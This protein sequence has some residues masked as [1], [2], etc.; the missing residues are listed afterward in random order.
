MKKILFG[1][2]ILFVLVIIGAAVAPFVINLD[3]HKG[4]ILNKI[5]PYI[6]RE[7]DFD[8]V[9]LTV[10][11]GFGAELQGFRISG[12]PSFYKEDFLKLESLKIKIRL[13]PLLK[14]EYE[15]KKIILSRPLIRLARNADGQFCFNDL[16]AGVDSDQEISGEK[17]APEEA[18]QGPGILGVLLVNNLQIEKAKIIYQDDKQWPGAGALVI[19]DIDL[20]VK[21]FSLKQPVSV[22]LAA[23]LL[24]KGDKQ[25]FNLAGQIGPLGEEIAFDK[26]PM[27]VQVLFAALPIES[28]KAR[29]PADLPLLPLSGILNGKLTARGSLAAQLTSESQIDVQDLIIQMLD[30]AQA[31]RNSTPVQISF[32]H[33]IQLEY[34]NEKM[35]VESAALSLNGNRILVKGNVQNFLKLPKWDARIWTETFQPMSLAALMP[36]FLEKMPA[37]LELKG[38]AEITINSAGTKDSFNFDI[39]TNMAQM[40]VKYEE[41]FKKPAGTPFSLLSKGDKAAERITLKELKLNLHDLVMTTAGEIIQSAKPRFSLRTQTNSI[42][43]E[44]WEDLV[45]LLAPYNP[46]GSLFLRSSLFGK[47]NDASMNVQIS[48]DQVQFVLPA[49]EDEKQKKKA[50][51]PGNLQSLNLQR[52]VKKN[53]EGVLGSGRIEIKKGEIFINCLPPILYYYMV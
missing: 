17:D 44:G 6:P 33:N 2:A 10:L 3:K 24:E 30:E 20:K 48:S 36:M 37:E 7:V 28:L 19:D 38:P 21:D 45:P 12:N 53:N 46:R 52:Q 42:S 27:D 40:E 50:A 31:A 23:R 39:N 9:E 29:L 4:T 22:E 1:I 49:A 14:K 34:S 16:L 5:K 13:L 32:A 51:S 26:I 18:S 43:L 11:T 25:N 41:L 35:S 15:I 8:H 47:L